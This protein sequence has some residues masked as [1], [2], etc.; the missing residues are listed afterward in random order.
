[1][2]KVFFFLEFVM[3]GNLVCL[4]DVFFWRV[5]CV[6]QRNVFL[7]SCDDGVKCYV[8]VFRLVDL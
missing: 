7:L 4:N 5:F 3:M 1:M 6:E 2:K 8:F